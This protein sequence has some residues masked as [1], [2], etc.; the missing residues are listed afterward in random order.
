MIRDLQSPAKE[1]VG[2][3]VEDFLRRLG[4][5]TWIRLAGRDR[6]RTRAITTLLHG[7]EPSGI[8]ALHGIL[9]G[10]LQPATDVLAL[11]AS[12]DAALA[13]PG[14][15][16]RM[17]PGHRDL[18]RCFTDRLAGV[19]GD[20][21]HAILEGL[22]AAR[23]EALIDLHNTSGAGPAYG[24]GTRA[25]SR[26]FALTSAFA[27][28]YVL[29]DLRLGALMEA[30][31][32]D[33][34]TVTIECGGAQSRRSDS[35]A[36]EGLQRYLGADDVLGNPESSS[37][38]FLLKHPVRVQLVNGAAVAYSSAPDADRPV[39]LRRD[40]DRFNSSV[41]DPSEPVGWARRLDALSAKDG[42][43]RERVR[44]F[45][46]LRDGR[47]HARRPLRLFMATTDARIALDD[48]LFY[49]TFSEESAHVG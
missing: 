13:A 20:L 32:D 10:G 29:T 49:A 36:A 44:D 43:G 42:G 37:R 4:G 5:P 16:H 27:A 14:F 45:F 6:S 28:T 1:D 33:F 48:C 35:V 38:V 7:N 3:D 40:I 18:N 46:E 39:T 17:L 25:E 15:A 11:V 19:E 9:A 21:A 41:L 8:R 23:P 34:P 2:R 26:H 47:L 12:V 24:V 30:T 22:R 31:Q